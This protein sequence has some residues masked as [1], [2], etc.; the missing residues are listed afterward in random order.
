MRLPQG[1]RAASGKGSGTTQATLDGCISLVKSLPTK[2]HHVGNSVDVDGLI[3]VSNSAANVAH[4]QQNL[5]GQLPLDGE[6]ER[7][8]DVGTE[9]RVECLSGARR[10][11]VDTREGRL[12]KRWGSSGNR[13]VV[14]I[15]SDAE[16]IGDGGIG[17]PARAPVHNVLATLDRLNKSG[18]QQRDEDKVHAVQTSIDAAIAAADDA[19]C[20]RR[21]L[22]RGFH[23]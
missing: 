4:F 20:F 18:T 1:C 2:G 17:R 10:D 11:V 3:F 8:H 19:T 13:R 16:S 14:A 22:C 12:R 6:V 21:T 5:V 9:M 7:V 15:G 23:R